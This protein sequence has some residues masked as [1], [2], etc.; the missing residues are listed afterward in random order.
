MRADY[1]PPPKKGQKPL[2]TGEPHCLAGKVFLVTGI[3]ESIE[4]DEAY[5][6]I[7]KHGGYCIL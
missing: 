5:A 6:L 4:R 2:P 3:L 1:I 7:V